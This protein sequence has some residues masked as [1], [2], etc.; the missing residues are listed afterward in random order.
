[1]RRDRVPRLCVHS[2]FYS[3]AILSFWFLAAEALRLFTGITS[4]DG[5]SKL[6]EHL[7]PDKR[8]W[9]HAF[10]RNESHSTNHCLY[11]SRHSSW[12]PWDPAS[13]VSTP[14][15]ELDCAPPLSNHRMQNSYTPLLA[16]LS[17]LLSGTPRLPHYLRTRTTSPCANT[18]TT[19]RTK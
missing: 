12:S 16:G 7:G 14:V 5:Y 10:T 9:P 15:A 8:V 6:T 18:M 19:W 3:G 1:M 2:N 13:P 4:A 17:A 11:R